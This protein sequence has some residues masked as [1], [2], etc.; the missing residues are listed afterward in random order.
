MSDY[1]RITH[2]NQPPRYAEADNKPM[3]RKLALVD[4]KIE[5]LNGGEVAELLRAGH[6]VIRA[7]SGSA[8]K[9]E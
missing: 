2:G 4:M 6:H 1:F 3:A 7:D 9:T 8:P 5:R